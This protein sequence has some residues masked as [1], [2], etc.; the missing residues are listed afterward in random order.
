MNAQLRRRLEMAGRVREFLRAHKTDGVGEGLGLAKLEELVQRAEVLASQQ[1]SGR[2]LPRLVVSERE[3]PLARLALSMQRLVGWNLSAVLIHVMNIERS[4]RMQEERTRSAD[5]GE[6]VHMFDGRV[7]KPAGVQVHRRFAFHFHP[8][9]AAHHHQLLVGRVKVPGRA[10]ASC[11]LDQ[12]DGRP[13]RWITLFHRQRE[14]VGESRILLELSR[15]RVLSHGFV[16]LLS[17][18]GSGH[19]G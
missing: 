14:A 5:A 6:L 16:G 1:R 10:T 2:R 7:R 4:I 19:Q 9:R 12:Q 18:R 11:A 17:D 3:P 15:R 13:V 8:A